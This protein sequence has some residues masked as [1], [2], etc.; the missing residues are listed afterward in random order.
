[1]RASS[2]FVGGPFAAKAKSGLA[3]VEMDAMEKL[4]ADLNKLRRDTSSDELDDMKR[5][6]VELLHEAC[7]TLKASDAATNR[8]AVIKV[9]F[10]SNMVED[11]CKRPN[12]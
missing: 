3:I 10:E 11:I 6:V 7:W 5:D 2:S 4:T 12:E 8:A 1:M 9:F